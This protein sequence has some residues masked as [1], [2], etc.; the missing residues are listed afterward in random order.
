MW[1]IDKHHRFDPATH[2]AWYK[3]GRRVE[4]WAHTLHSFKPVHHLEPGATGHCSDIKKIKEKRKMVSLL[5]SHQHS[6]TYSKL[7]QGSSLVLGQNS[8]LIPLTSMWYM[9]SSRLHGLLTYFS[10]GF[11]GRRGLKY[12]ALVAS[13]TNTHEHWSEF[14]ST[15]ILSTFAII[16]YTTY[17]F[18]VCIT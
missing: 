9:D 3:A 16:M 6:S 5:T 8:K 13:H 11:Y 15:Y 1:G 17:L 7:F 14:T 2:K 18:K 12:Y 4:G 10:L